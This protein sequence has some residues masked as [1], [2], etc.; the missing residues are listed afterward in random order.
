MPAAVS[1]TPR[2][3]RRNRL[4]PSLSSR[5]L[6][7]WLRGGCAMCRRMAAL[8]K[9]NSSAT[10]MNCLSRRVSIILCS[11]IESN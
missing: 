5:R 1:L 10:A 8:W 6:I 11:F 3:L 4:N 7:A 9:C 2:L